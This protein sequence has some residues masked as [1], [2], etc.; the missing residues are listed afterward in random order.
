[1]ALGSKLYLIILTTFVFGTANAQVNEDSLF[2]KKIS[3]EIL[4]HGEAYSNL[5]NLCKSIGQRL[6]GSAGMYKAEDWGIRTLKNSGAENA[7]KQECMVPHWVRGKVAYAGFYTKNH[8]RDPY[9]AV[10]A[11]GN[12]VGT[13]KNGIKAKIIEIKNFEELNAR[14]NEVKGKIV[15]YNY[16]YNKKILGGA[17]GDAVKYRGGGASAAAKY[18]AVAVLVRSVTA[19]HDWNPHTGA[20]RYNDSFPKIPALAIST[21]HADELNLYLYK[22]YADADFFI[23]SNAQMLADTIGHNIIGEI[24]GSEFPD[25]I[26][27][28]GGHLDSWDLGEG[29]HDDG[30]GM[31]QSIEILRVFKALGYKPKRTIR[32]V[33]F[34]NEE[35]GLRGGTKYMEE[36]KA[37]NEKHIMAMESDGGGETPRGF[38]CGMTEQQFAKVSQWKSLFTMLDADKFNFSKGGGGGADIGPLQTAFK[39]A[40]FGLNTVGNRY[41]DYHHAATD[42]FENVHERELHLGAVVMASMVY[43]VDKYGL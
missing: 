3:D 6:S 35:N 7:Y 42:V 39:T 8:D 16:P 24:K 37:K 17:Y 40:Q 33:L 9:F 41:F 13:G 12:S 5:R 29:A 20:L 30:A 34:A 26:I 4:Q 22:Q 14:K 32:I 38:G 1:M 2:I 10:A 23:K 11:L 19:A 18:G 21:K 15:F 36:A 27:T 31:V 25:E 43:L 28:I